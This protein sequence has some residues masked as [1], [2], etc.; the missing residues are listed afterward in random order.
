MY[1][2]ILMFMHIPIPAKE[3]MRDEPPALTKGKGMPAMGRMP[4]A[5]PMLM[6][7]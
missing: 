4:S 5:I 1:R 2:R 7:T 6:V 3:E